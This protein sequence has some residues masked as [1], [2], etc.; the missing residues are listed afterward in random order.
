MFGDIKIKENILKLYKTGFFHIFS[1]N[2]INKILLFCNGIFIVKILSKE[3]FGIYSYSQNLLSV[4]LL[5]NGLG[6]NNGLLQFASKS[7]EREKNEIFKFSL[8]LGIIVNIILTGMVILYCFFGE[9]KIKEGKYLRRKNDYLAA[10]DKERAEDLM[11]M[12]KNKEVKAIIAY[13]GGYG[14]IR[15]LPYLDMGVIKKNPKIL[16]GYSDLTVLLNYLSQ[17]TGWTYDKF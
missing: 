13:R 1:S 6:I 8:R 9:F 2:V 11:E 3:N 14:C 17:K 4:F 7:N 10:S 16:C 15:M 5:F 12:F